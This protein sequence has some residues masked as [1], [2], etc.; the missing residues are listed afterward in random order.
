ML[1]SGAVVQSQGVNWGIDVKGGSSMKIRVEATQVDVLFDNY[2]KGQAE[3]I[4]EN[5]RDEFPRTKPLPVREGEEKVKIEIGERVPKERIVPLIPDKYEVNVNHKVSDET[6]EEVIE[7]LRLRVD[8]YGTLGAQ[9]KSIGDQYINFEV[10]LDIEEARY[11]LGEVGH[12]EIFVDDKLV[13]RGDQITNVRSPTTSGKLGPHIPFTWNEKASE[14]WENATE[15]KAGY[16][17]VIYLDRPADSVILFNNEFKLDF[18][19]DVTV[20]PKIEEGEHIENRFRLK[21]ARRGGSGEWFN[22]QVPAFSVDK[23]I[24]EDLESYLVKK[25]NAGKLE[26]IILLGEGYDNE[27]EKKENLKLK[28]NVVIPIENHRIESDALSQLMRIT[29]IESYP[30][31][32]EGI[33]GEKIE[34][35]VIT[36]GSIEE[37]GELRNILAQSLPADVEIVSE[38]EMPARLG[39]GFDDEVLLAGIFALLAVGIIVFIRYRNP[40][41]ALPLMFTVASEVIITLGIVSVLPSSLITMGIAEIG[42]LIAVIGFGVDNQV[43]ITDEVLYGGT[44]EEKQRL[45]IERRTQKA[46]S[47]IFASVS[48][49]IAAMAA[50]ATVGLGAMRGFAIVT[51]IGSLISIGISRP[52]YASILG[53]LLEEE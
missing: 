14:E 13:I 35:L 23:K 39:E 50:L 31:I 19:E 29:G 10:A 27:L 48:T 36:S 49:T 30:N 38:E 16:P 9:F 17:G 53:T 1:I 46:Y 4:L 25:K 5:L 24:G 2:S 22:V 43:M 11:L 34:D 8:P 33:A 44:S 32:Q 20:T 41:I 15:G 28:D 12:L 40:K 37:A 52:A 21:P 42:G 6:I 3:N 7:A 45:S 18:E 47:I 51:I 26:K